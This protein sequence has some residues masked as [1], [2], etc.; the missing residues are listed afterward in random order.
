[1]CAFYLGPADAHAPVAS[2]LGAGASLVRF[3]VLHLLAMH[4]VIRCW[5]FGFVCVLLLFP[6]V[7]FFYQFSSGYALVFLSATLLQGRHHRFLPPTLPALGGETSADRVMLFW[8]CF[9]MDW[10]GSSFPR[11]V[12][13]LP[14]PFRAS[15]SCCACRVCYKHV[16]AP[17]PR[18]RWHSL[19]PLFVATVALLSPPGSTPCL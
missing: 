18:C 1:M 7:F 8:I 15:L 11:C 2:L 12:A 17:Q 9:D 14:F 5:W 13:F 3:P 4:S 6:E 10:I 16:A 19:H